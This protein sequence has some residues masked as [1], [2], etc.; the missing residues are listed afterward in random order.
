MTVQCVCLIHIDNFYYVC[1]VVL[2]RLLL[3]AHLRL[4]MPVLSFENHF[5]NGCILPDDFLRK[6]AA[7]NPLKRVIGFFY[8]LDLFLAEFRRDIV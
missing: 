7:P 6:N 2:R 5:A 1:P 4:G 8:F 3:V